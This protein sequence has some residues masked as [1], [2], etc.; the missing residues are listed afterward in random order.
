MGR[1]GEWGLA[2]YPIRRWWVDPGVRMGVATTVARRSKPSQ[3]LFAFA[4]E[5]RAQSRP[6]SPEAKRTAASVSV[7]GSGTL[8]G[9]GVPVRGGVNV[10][11]ATAGGTTFGDVD[12]VDVDVD[13]DGEVDVD[14]VG[15]I[16]WACGVE[17]CTVVVG[18]E[19]GVGSNDP[20]SCPRRWCQWSNRAGS[21]ERL[22]S[23]Y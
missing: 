15:R 18:A 23:R 19:L 22:H 17:P 5:R 12:G 1:G 16:C 14:D 3:A 8:A 20:S 21:S 4:L 10:S 7:S 13:V 2:P 11:G 9:D 6:K